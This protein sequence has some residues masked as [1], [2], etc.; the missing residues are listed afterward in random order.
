MPDDD[1]YVPTVPARIA[2]LGGRAIEHGLPGAGEAPEHVE[3]ALGFVATIER[4]YAH[5]PA[6][7]DLLASM[8]NDV[9]NEPK[10]RIRAAQIVIEQAAKAAGR[11]GEEEGDGELSALE[12][13][14]AAAVRARSA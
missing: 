13:L 10:D 7:V 6:M 2:G 3:N 5:G 12:T 8:A 14:A 4:A 1:D 11:P 9:G